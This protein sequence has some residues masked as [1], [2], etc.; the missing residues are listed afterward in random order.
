MNVFNWI[1]NVCVSEKFQYGEMYIIWVLC[2]NN[3]LNDPN[4][5]SSYNI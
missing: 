4:K 1:A 2:K 5:Y 3:V